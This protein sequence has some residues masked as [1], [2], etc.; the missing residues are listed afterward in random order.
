MIGTFLCLAHYGI[1][2][3]FPIVKTLETVKSQKF[4]S[5]W[6]SYWLTF[7]F[8]TYVEINLLWFLCCNCLFCTLKS[9]FCLWM[10]HQDYRGAEWLEE[11][12]FNKAFG[13]I[14]ELVDKTPL[15]SLLK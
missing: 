6:L 15:K 11:N 10:H 12:V 7:G 14:D 4:D 9:V 1:C 8:L 5:L 3:L 2:W 13:A